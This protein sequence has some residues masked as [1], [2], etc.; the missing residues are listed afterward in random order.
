[1]I[2]RRLYPTISKY[3]QDHRAIVILGPRRVGKTTLLKQ[4]IND[5]PNSLLL[6]G[7]EK[8][9]QLLFETGNIESFRKAFGEHKMILLDEAQRIPNIGIKLKLIT[10]GLPQIKLVLTG[11]SAFHL[12]NSIQEMLTG[13][14]WDFKMFPL[15]Y[16]EMVEDH[17]WL[18]EKQLLSERLIFGYYPEVVT[19]QKGLHQKILRELT[20]E[21]LYKDILLWQG[22]KRSEKLYDLL[23]CL[24]YQVGHE[25]TYTQLGKLIN[26]DNETIEKYIM[27]LEQCFIVFRLPAYSRNLRNEIKK[28]RKIYFYDNGVRNALISNFQSLDLRN[29]IGALWENFLISERL[30]FKEYH[31]VYSSSYFWRTTD[32][33][34]IDYIEEK[35]GKLSCYEFKWN[36]EKGK[37]IPKSFALSYPN[38]TYQVIHRENF[39]AFVGL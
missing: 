1:M 37:S 34:E 19:D 33:A 32:Q 18:K 35:D 21:Y 7:D 36:P 23:R 16:A 8:E 20:Q 39:E 5:Y 26:L 28:G 31:E 12:T 27:L 22:I 2:L 14:K 13:R 10:D 15:S 25:V 24:A 30:K 29:D 11:S 38:H 3:L 9:I 17:G 6:N 4:L